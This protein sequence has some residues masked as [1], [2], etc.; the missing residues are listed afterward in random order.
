MLQYGLIAS[1]IGIGMALSVWTKKLTLSA[2][3]I[4]GLLAFLIYMGSGLLGLVLLSTFFIIASLATI[5]K[6]AEKQTKLLENNDHKRRNAGQVWANAGL[7]GLL[8]VLAWIFPAYQDVFITML[9]A[10]F[11][12]ALSDT[13]SSELGNVYGKFFYNII[14][15]KRDRK[16]LNGVISVEGTLF[17]I[18]GS[19]LIALIY[20]LFKGFS[21]DFWIIILAG[22]LGNLSDSILGATLERRNL[23]TNNAVNFSNTVVA[24]LVSLFFRG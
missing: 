22:T 1:F 3:L 16:G 2:S 10:C 24:A 20:G 4:G 23:L 5:W 7:A 17:G 14:S 21:I 19:V 13:L 6:S 11:S 9:A 15:L 8:G 12:S 18:A